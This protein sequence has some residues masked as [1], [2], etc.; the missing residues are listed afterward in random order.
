ME[1]LINLCFVVINLIITTLN[2]K[3][4]TEVFK[5]RRISERKK[6]KE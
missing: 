5:D 4:Y 6:E 3:L 1:V 2:V